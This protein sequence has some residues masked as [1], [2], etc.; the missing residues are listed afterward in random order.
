MD[1]VECGVNMHHWHGGQG[2]PVYMVG[3]F[4]VCDEDYPDLDI[5]AQAMRNLEGDLSKAESGKVPGW[6]RTE[7][8][9]LGEIIE[10][11]G[12]YLTDHG[13]VESED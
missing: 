8:A 4:F 6:G 5:V 9:E 10:F 13:Y 1:R 3:S 7:I 2:D 12:G 11:L